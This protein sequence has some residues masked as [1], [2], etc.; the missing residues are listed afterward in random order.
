MERVLLN[1][2]VKDI[3]QSWYPE[4]DLDQ[5]KITRGGMIAWFFGRFFKAAAV[6]IGR[7]IYFTKKSY[8][9][10]GDCQDICG[11]SLLVH[12]LK[13]VEQCEKMG[14]G[15]FILKYIWDWVAAGFRD[16][17]YL[18]LEVPAYEI[19]KK[20]IKNQKGVQR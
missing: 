17:L 19:Q 14:V 12:E 20:F 1:A 8:W 3:L 13:H 16:G 10:P 11:L 15:H 9:H 6:T 7:N 18:P 4:L 2:K 5:V